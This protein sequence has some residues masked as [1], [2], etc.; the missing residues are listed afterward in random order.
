M[1]KIAAIAAAPWSFIDQGS[2]GLGN[3]SSDRP[4]CAISHAAPVA[5]SSVV[6]AYSIQRDCAVSIGPKTR[7]CDRSGCLI[8]VRIDIVVTL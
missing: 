1:A 5:T 6:S 3:A 2:T 7:G 8:D 4:K